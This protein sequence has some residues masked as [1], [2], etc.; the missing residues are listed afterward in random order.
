MVYGFF[1]LLCALDL[2]NT[3][4]SV[5]EMSEFSL[6]DMKVNGVDLQGATHEQAASALK[7]AGDVV[8]L[9]AL[10][11]PEGVTA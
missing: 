1:Q 4:F 8:E 2:K 6:F 3:C 7:G 11:R 10:Y 5:S 9:V